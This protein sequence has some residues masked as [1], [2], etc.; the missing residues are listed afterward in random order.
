M[1]LVNIYNLYVYKDFLHSY[2]KLHFFL[3]FGLWLGINIY[4]SLINSINFNCIVFFF[5]F[6][7]AS[8]FLCVFTF[9][10]QY[11]SYYENTSHNYY[12]HY[13]LLCTNFS[14]ILLSSSFL[15]FWYLHSLMKWKNL[16]LSF[17]RSIFIYFSHQ[18]YILGICLCLSYVSSLLLVSGFCMKKCQNNDVTWCHFHVSF[19]NDVHQKLTVLNEIEIYFSKTPKVR[20]SFTNVFYAFSL[21]FSK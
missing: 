9:C 1:N 21:I 3:I 13:S 5:F 19:V 16:S 2:L 20:T 6:S 4:F 12:Y 18:K 15:L 14:H 7:Y 11:I 10:C 17:Y 8:C